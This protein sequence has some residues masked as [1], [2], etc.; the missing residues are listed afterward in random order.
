MASQH[1][2][3]SGLDLSAALPAEAPLFPLVLS[4]LLPS[5]DG[6][7]QGAVWIQGVSLGEV[8]V[9]LT[10][11]AAIRRLREDLPLLVTS[12]TPAGVGLVS[13]KP[14]PDGA[15]WRPFPLDLP[16]SVRR[17][18]DAERPRVLALVETELWP[19]VLNEARRRGVPVLLANARLSERSARRL[20]RAGALFKGPVS[21]LTRV[22]ARTQADAERFLSIGVAPERVTVSGDL[23]FD[24]DEAALPAFAAD[25]RRLAA[26]RQVLV[27][28]SIAEDE[29]PLVLET[30][31]LLAAMAPVFLVL[32]PR[33][34]GSFDAAE[35]AVRDAGLVVVRRSALNSF[36]GRAADVLLLDTVG[37]LAGTYGLGDAALLGGT[38]APKGGHNI[39]EPLRAGLPTVVGP[40]I[41]NI[42]EAVEAAGSAVANARDAPSAASALHALLRESPQRSA[43]RSA[44][45]ALFAGNSGAAGRTARAVLDLLAPGDA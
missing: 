1:K 45:R 8:E 34:P 6:L 30:R 7:R 11:A 4:R 44:A 24:R 15:S 21:A 2:F 12:T 23:K 27:A 26:G 22:L 36:E 16:L 41:E 29:V 39:L 42:R 31:R 19:V 38:F 40:S 10:L 18:F 9:A 17:F 35:R 13:R 3:L 28:G 32:A 5:G 33:Q 20:G 37:E 25:A 14:L 43:S